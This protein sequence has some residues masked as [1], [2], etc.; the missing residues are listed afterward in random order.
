VGLVIGG[1]M[2]SP[3]AAILVRRIKR[4]PLMIMVG[5]MVILLSLRTIWLS[6]H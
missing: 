6:M 5:I 3:F 4:R 1:V 2:A